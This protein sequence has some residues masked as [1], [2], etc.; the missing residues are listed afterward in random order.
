MAQSIV[1]QTNQGIQGEFTI[2]IYDQMQRRLRD[3]GCIETRDIIKSGMPCF[4]MVHFT[5]GVSLRIHSILLKVD[6]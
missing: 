4:Q 3:K 6:I 1:T 5:S 2:K